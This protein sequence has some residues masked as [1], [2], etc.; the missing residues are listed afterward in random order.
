MTRRMILPLLFGLGGAAILIWLGTWQV[1]RLAWKEGVL[2]KMDAQLVGEAVALPDTL[3]PATDNYSAVTLKGRILPREIHVLTSRQ[4]YGPGYRVISV[5]ETTTRN[6]LVDRGFIGQR[7]KDDPRP[8]VDARIAG[9][10]LWPNEVDKSFTPD[11]DM[12]AN[13]WFARDLPA[14][15]AHLGTEPVLVVV[16]TTSEKN[17]PVRPWPVTTDIPND[18]LQY[19]ITWYSLAVLWLGMTGYLL[20]RIRRRLD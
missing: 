7:R 18:H 12:G 4:N 17:S 16:R 2:A 15:A 19:A 3:D 11:P 8:A 1:Q 6:I 20:W 9:N 10:L 14:M 5:L 13:I